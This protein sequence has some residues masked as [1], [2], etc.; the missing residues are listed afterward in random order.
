MQRCCICI[1]SLNI[2]VFYPLNLILYRD[3][4]SVKIIFTDPDPHHCFDIQSYLTS[5]AR[6]LAAFNQILD[7]LIFKKKKKK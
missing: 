7:E 6:L 1:K 2:K 4:G 3:L 5:N